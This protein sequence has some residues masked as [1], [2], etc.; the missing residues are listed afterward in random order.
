MSH[1]YDVIGSGNGQNQ[2]LWPKFSRTEYFA[3]IFL[4]FAYSGGILN[5]FH[6]LI[7]QSEKGIFLF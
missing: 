5:K 1:N 4:E 3:S 7:V 2:I 6:V